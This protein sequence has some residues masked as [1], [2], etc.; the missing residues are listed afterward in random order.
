MAT[1]IISVCLSC[2]PRC[3]CVC[4]C[5][6]LYSDE[7]IYVWNWRRN[8]KIEYV[9]FGFGVEMILLLQLSHN[10]NFVLEREDGHK[11]VIQFLALNAESAKFRGTCIFKALTI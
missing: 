6:I 1:E 9:H 8:E 4:I 2:V 5:A 7:T 10:V 11:M 3:V